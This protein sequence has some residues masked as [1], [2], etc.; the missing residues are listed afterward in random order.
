LSDVPAIR[1]K[2]LQFYVLWTTG[3]SMWT[4][5][6]LIERGSKEA[7]GILSLSPPSERQRYCFMGLCVCL[8][9][10]VRAVNRSMHTCSV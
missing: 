3:S 6:D 5:N 8:S 4:D 7:N 2:P 1:P 10:C 9:V